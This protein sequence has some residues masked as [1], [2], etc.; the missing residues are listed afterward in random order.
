M[1]KEGDSFINVKHLLLPD[2]PHPKSPLVTRREFLDMTWR[3]L[4]LAAGSAAISA[5]NLVGIPTDPDSYGDPGSERSD[6]FVVTD[7]GKVAFAA[8][9]SS[10]GLPQKLLD[11]VMKL[12]LESGGSFSA[13]VQSAEGTQEKLALELIKG[14]SFPPTKENTS[15]LVMCDKAQKRWFKVSPTDG[16]VGRLENGMKAIDE[17]IRLM[18]YELPDGMPRPAV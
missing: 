8:A 17:E 14:S 15:Y 13:V 16:M 4:T 1:S 10:D 18:G 11:K 2:N 6:K 9:L 7:P 5:C 12:G 3:A